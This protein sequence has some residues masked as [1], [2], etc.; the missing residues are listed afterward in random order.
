[1]INRWL[2]MISR[3]DRIAHILIFELQIIRERYDMN[4]NNLFHS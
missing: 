4:D 3:N 1:M 2:F